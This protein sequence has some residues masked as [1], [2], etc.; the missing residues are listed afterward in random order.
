MTG[1]T[2]TT[3]PADTLA[4]T[5]AEASVELS[6]AALAQASGGAV[7][8]SGPGFSNLKIESSVKLDTDPALLLPAKPVG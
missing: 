5:S 6:E 1:S 2:K 4:K 7:F 8:P 3:S